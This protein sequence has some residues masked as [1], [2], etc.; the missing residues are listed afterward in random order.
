MLTNFTNDKVAELLIETQVPGFIV[1]VETDPYE[2]TLS[3]GEVITFFH[4]W[5]YSPKGSIVSQLE[6]S[7]LTLHFLSTNPGH[8]KSDRNFFSL[9]KHL[10][11]VILQ[12]ASRQQTRIRLGIFGPSGSGKTFGARYRAINKMI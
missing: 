3:N 9:T 4:R 8:V 11:F 7:F 5:S 2:F 10:K 12:K 1:K 6:P